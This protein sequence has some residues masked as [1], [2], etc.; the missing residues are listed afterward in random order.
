MTEEGP[1]KEKELQEAKQR[2]DNL[3]QGLAKGLGQ[4]GSP[5]ELKEE[6]GKIQEEMDK[7]K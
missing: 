5:E 7:Y 4:T 2:T 3:S 6:A 1:Q